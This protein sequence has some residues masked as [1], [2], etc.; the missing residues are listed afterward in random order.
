[1]DN[2]RLL[3]TNKVI[4]YIRYKFYFT[5]LLHYILSYCLLYICYILC[6]F[7]CLFVSRAENNSDIGY[8]FA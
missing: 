4:N 1:M 6:I 2:D 5:K 3:K 7:V 8:S